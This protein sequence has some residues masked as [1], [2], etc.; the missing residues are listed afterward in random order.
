MCVFMVA[1]C[2]R[3]P[4]YFCPVV[5]TYLSI[6]LSIDLSIYR[7]IDRSIDRSI[8]CREVTLPRRE[9]HW[10]L[11]ECPKLTKRSQPLVGRSSP[12]YTD[13]WRRYCCLTSCSPIVDTC[14]CCEDIA[15]QSC[16]MAP[17]WP[18]FGDFLVL[19]FQRAACST[20]QTCILNSH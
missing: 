4:L 11:E 13:M 14:L 16:A 19:Y 18:I 5:S 7:S 9:T 12:Y 1:L 20:F 2:N 3:G 10:D 6:C 8:E 15:Q 17:R